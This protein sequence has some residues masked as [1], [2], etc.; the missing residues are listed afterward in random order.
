MVGERDVRAR[1]DAYAEELVRL[2][3]E[4]V[5]TRLR[6]RMGTGDWREQLERAAALAER[7]RHLGAQVQ[8][9]RWAPLEEAS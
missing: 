6:V 5:A 3:A 7:R 1:R 4:I 8:A 2:D 9:L